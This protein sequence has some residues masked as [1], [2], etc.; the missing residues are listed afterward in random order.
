MEN[1]CNDID[2]LKMG[3]FGEKITNLELFT[4]KS[5]G[6]GGLFSTWGYG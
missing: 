3:R 6:G 5:R 1:L 4:P 2:G